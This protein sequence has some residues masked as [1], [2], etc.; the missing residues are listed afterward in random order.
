MTK[1]LLDTNICSYAVK[2]LYDGIGRRLLLIN[3]DDIFVSCITVSEF[4]YGA[5][6]KNWGER[7]RN[8]MR[9]FMSN[10]DA[11]P[12]T[13]SDAIAFGCLRADFERRGLVVGI[14]D[15]MIGSQAVNNDLILVTHNVKDFAG[16]PGINI[17]DWANED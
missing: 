4:E 14:L 3:P 15:L 10:F 1:Y 8:T 6:R 17:E 16:I 7:A 11:L 12:F 2:G 13:E 5:S 9:A